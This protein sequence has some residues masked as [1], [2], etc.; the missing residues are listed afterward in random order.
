RK[1]TSRAALPRF[2]A[3]AR[4]SASSALNRPEMS[5]TGISVKFLV[6][7]LITNLST[8]GETVEMLAL[9]A[10]HPLVQLPQVGNR[11]IGEGQVVQVAIRTELGGHG[12]YLHAATLLA[13]PD[14]FPVL[15]VEGQGVGVFRRTRV[16]DL[17]ALVVADP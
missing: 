8:T 11:H 1:P 12:G 9:A 13:R 16:R 14:R 3:T 10:A 7:L 4:R 2:S 5:T 17:R 15:L 6:L